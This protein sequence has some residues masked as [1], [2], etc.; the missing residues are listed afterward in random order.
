[1]ALQSA[2]KLLYS[3][4]SVF[5][6]NERLVFAD[7]VGLSKKRSRRRRIVGGSRN[8]LAFSAI[9]STV[10]AVVDVDRFNRN[11]SVSNAES[12]SSSS[13]DQQVYYYC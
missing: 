7:F 1:M 12:T 9:S 4:P 3:S 8:L 2:P 10:K 11:D 13:F 6:V 5:S